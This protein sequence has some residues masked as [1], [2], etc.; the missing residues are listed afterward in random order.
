MDA[1]RIG[2]AIGW[3]PLV[4]LLVGGLGVAAGAAA[5]AIWDEGVR[6]VAVVVA[7]TAVTGG[8]HLDGLADTFDGMLSWRPRAQRLEIMRDSRIGTMGAL[9]LIAVLGGKAALLAGA[10]DGWAVPVLVAPVLGR[11]ADVVAIL[12]FP[13]AREGGLGRTFRE[14]S[15][16]GTLIIAAITAVVVAGAAAGWLGLLAVASVTVVT[17]LLGRWWV[18]ALGGLTGDTYGA[19][20]EIGELVAL[21]TLTASLAA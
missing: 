15:G 21:A 4:G 8:I 5:G 16:R 17:L 3:F 13:A 19:A 12:A 9:A 18:R 14:S 7:W 11:W 20:S 1:G 10:G 6:A 2:Q